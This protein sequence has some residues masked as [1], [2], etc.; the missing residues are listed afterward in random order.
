MTVAVFDQLYS[1]VDEKALMAHLR[2][3][4]RWQKLSGSKDELAN[5]EYVQKQLE[6]LGY[7]TQLILHD[8]YISLPLEAK[9][10][11]NSKS[12]RCITH[13]FSRTTQPEGLTAPLVYLGKE[14]DTA[15]E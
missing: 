8:A 4:A 10:I 9:V 12:L 6:D 2:E 13:S 14:L 7:E 5:V 3:F 11:V 1:A 15:N